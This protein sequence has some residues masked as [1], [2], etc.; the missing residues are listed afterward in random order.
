ME[1]NR[2]P[3]CSSGFDSSHVSEVRLISSTR[4][5]SRNLGHTELPQGYVISQ[6]TISELALKT[7]SYLLTMA[8][9]DYIKNSGISSPRSDTSTPATFPREHSARCTPASKSKL[10]L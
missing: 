8:I 10:K 7:I 6:T 2:S 4:I 1:R 9:Q 3:Q 5:W